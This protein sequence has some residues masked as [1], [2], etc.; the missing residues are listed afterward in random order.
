M[1]SPQSAYA[2]GSSSPFI[3]GSP[4]SISMMSDYVDGFNDTLAESI[5]VVCEQARDGIRSEA[6]KDPEWEPYADL[7]DVEFND[8]AFEYVLIGD[9][10]DIDAALAIEYGSIEGHSPNSILRK[11][12]ISQAY[13]MGQDLASALGEEL[14]FA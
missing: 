9:Q 5:A 11:T 1:A 6:R 4:S 3:S 10:T 8:G 7:L 12:A 2:R 14:P 13:T